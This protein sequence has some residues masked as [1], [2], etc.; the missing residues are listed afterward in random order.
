MPKFLRN[1]VGGLP[2][3]PTEL[4]YTILIKNNN[5]NDTNQAGVPLR[6]QETR[7]NPYLNNAADYYMSVVAYE[8]DSQSLPVFI[9]DAVPGNTANVNRTPYFVTITD[10]G[11]LYSKEMVSWQPQDVTAPVPPLPVPANYSTY[12]Y[13]Y[14][15]TFQHFINLV[16]DAIVSAYTGI[17]G[18]SYPP[19]LQIRDNQISVVASV[20]EFATSSPTYFLNFNTELYELFSSLVAIQ[21]PSPI[22]LNMEYQLQFIAYPDNSNVQTV[23]TDFTTVPPSLGYQA[24]F[25]NCEYSPLPYWN[26]IESIV[27]TTQQLTVV[28]E[29]IAQPTL[30]GTTNS[31]FVLTNADTYYVL[32][33]YAA[34]LITGTE[35]K[36][37]I[38]YEP[39]SE[40]H[41]VD[42]YG[43][44]ELNSISIDVFWKDKFGILHQMFLEVGGTAYI[45]ILFRKKAFYDNSD[46]K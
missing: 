44:Q 46:N 40:F 29:L 7:S 18:T 36:S 37:T 23:Y 35:Y 41:L 42:L 25:N 45:K 4:F 3:D 38:A 16:N 39:T 34:N 22:T 31:Q 14:A 27:F 15:Y 21:P 33:D 19:Y 10:N 1:D 6:F 13:Y 30:Y 9:C 2:P 28:P 43:E 20:A 5:I 24:I 32:A 12:P 11:F 8:V 17:G 26:P